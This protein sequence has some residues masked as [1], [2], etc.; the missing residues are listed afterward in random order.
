MTNSDT[1]V[2]RCSETVP[3]V[4]PSDIRLDN[5]VR[6][7]DQPE[8]GQPGQYKGARRDESGGKR[9]ADVSQKTFA[10]SAG[11][12]SRP[13]TIFCASHLGCGSTGPVIG[14]KRLLCV[15]LSVEAVRMPG[16]TN[17][18]SARDFQNRSS[19]QFPRRRSDQLPSSAVQIRRAAVQLPS[20][21]TVPFPP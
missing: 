5:D 4:T 8:G 2:N 20:R 9:S 21:V 14:S 18:A 6:V 10:S 19:W 12:I 3:V 11:R 15:E 16:R 17:A 1:G 13:V 7:A